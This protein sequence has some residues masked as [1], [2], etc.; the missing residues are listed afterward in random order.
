MTNQEVRPA[1]GVIG[2]TGPYAGLDLVRKIFDQT[3][4][5]TDQEHL[6][7]ALLSLPSAIPDRTDYLL[8]REVINPAAGI[9]AVALQLER[10]G[11]RVAAIACNT[12]HADAIFARL[13]DKLAEAHSGLRILHLIRETILFLQTEYRGWQRIGVLSTTGTY[14]VRLYAQPLEEAGYQVVLPTLKMQEER[15]H[16]AIYHPEV[17]LKAQ[18]NPVTL[19]ARQW[20]E[21]AIEALKADGAEAIIL[22]CTELPLAIPDPARPGIPLIDPAMVLARA[23]IREVAPHQLKPLPLLHCT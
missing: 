13:L 6:P 14:R 7:V 3:L 10:M 1:I 11:A 21:E 8:G 5:R 23:L 17:G 15:V 16:A 19:Q 9:A 2:G 20:V 4:A 18:S 22:G 12:A